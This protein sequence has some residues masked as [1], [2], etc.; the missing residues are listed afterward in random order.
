MQSTRFK[1][2]TIYD[3]KLLSSSL[4]NFCM[5]R[6]TDTTLGD[7]ADISDSLSGA[8]SNSKDTKDELSD[9][10]GPHFNLE[11]IPNINSK[12]VEDILFKVKTYAVSSFVVFFFKTRTSFPG[13]PNGRIARIS[14]E[15]YFLQYRRRCV[16]RRHGRTA[17]D[18]NASYFD[19]RRQTEHFTECG[20][21]E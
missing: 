13:C 21:S 16:S 17:A 11:T 6:I 10:L 18:D 7:A 12:D 2:S 3:G 5:Y 9:I 8:A 19:R 14:R 4:N 20:E 15:Q 1:K